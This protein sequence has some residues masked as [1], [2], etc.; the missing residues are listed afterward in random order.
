MCVR[1]NLDLFFHLFL[2]LCSND[3]LFYPQQQYVWWQYF[4][5]CTR[6]CTYMDCMAPKSTG[7]FPLVHCRRFVIDF[8]F[9]YEK[10]LSKNMQ[11]KERI[12]RFNIYFFIIFLFAS[13]AKSWRACHVSFS[14]LAFSFKNKIRR[15]SSTVIFFSVLAC[16]SILRVTY[17]AQGG[18]NTRN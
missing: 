17:C 8:F 12:A 11:E 5:I 14:G 9:W 4:I 15:A 7:D 16:V 1:A 3:L 10:T 18:N 6:L 13:K 2:V